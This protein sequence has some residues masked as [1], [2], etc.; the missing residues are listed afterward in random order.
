VARIGEKGNVYRVLVGKS[1]L[2]ISLGRRRRENDIKV[3]VKNKL[4]GWG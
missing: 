2:K 4:W 3:D 1:E